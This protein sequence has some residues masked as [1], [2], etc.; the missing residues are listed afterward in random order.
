MKEFN[1]ATNEIN[2]NVPSIQASLD[3]E[4]LSYTEAYPLMAARLC[5]AIADLVVRN[6]DHLFNDIEDVQYSVQNTYI[7]PVEATFTVDV[8]YYNKMK[9]MFLSLIHI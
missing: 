1:L 2:V 7:S 6:G 8:Y 5:C 9:G 3:R 4:V